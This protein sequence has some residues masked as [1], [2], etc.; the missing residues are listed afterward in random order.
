MTIYEASLYGVNP[1]SSH[2]R[3]WALLLDNEREHLQKIE[4]EIKRE[5]YKSLR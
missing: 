5:Y 1:E 2:K 3:N 4:K